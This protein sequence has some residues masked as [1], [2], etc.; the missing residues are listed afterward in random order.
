[1]LALL[2]YAVWQYA[3]D[4]LIPDDALGSEPNE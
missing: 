4:A 3:A 1:M 2:D